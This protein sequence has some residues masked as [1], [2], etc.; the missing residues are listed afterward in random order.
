MSLLNVSVLISS[1]KSL[2]VRIYT[3]HSPKSSTVLLCLL[4]IA[5]EK[6]RR[7]Q[8]SSVLPFYR[9]ICMPFSQGALQLT[10][11]SY[12][13]HTVPWSCQDCTNHQ[14]K[15]KDSSTFIIKRNKNGLSICDVLFCLS[16]NR[17]ELPTS[18]KQEIN[19]QFRSVFLSSFLST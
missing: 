10:T 14:K 4:K 9:K 15:R 17:I 1:S 2:I 18:Q 5:A 16:A 13:G 8:G 6:W 3:L 12:L 7:H 19:K 11:E